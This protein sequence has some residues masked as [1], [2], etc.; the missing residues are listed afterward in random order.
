MENSEKTSK[1]T[2]QKIR[3]KTLRL[4]SFICFCLIIIFS[5]CKCPRVSYTGKYVIDII[6]KKDPYVRATDNPG[7]AQKM[8]LPGVPNLHKVSDSLYRGA[9]PT[10]EGMKELKKMGVKT[11]IN[12]RSIHSD[13]DELKDVDLACEHIK[14]TTSKPKSE[15]IVS[16]LNIV[17]DSNNAPVFVHCHYGADR[18]GTMCAIYRIIVQGW[19]KEDAL[20]EMTK[21]GFGFHSIWGNLPNF[22]RKLDIEEIKQKAGLKEKTDKATP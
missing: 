12:L 14:M 5:A 4:F 10:E 9:Q 15:D 11:I 16:F 8:D 6:R 3:P 7:L 21:G 22:V 18:T 19:T 20:E 2:S 17:T 13:R 1:K